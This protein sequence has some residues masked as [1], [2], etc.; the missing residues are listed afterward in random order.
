MSY[1]L[2]DFRDLVRAQLDTDADDLTNPLIDAWVREGWRTCVN[3]NRRWPFYRSTWSVP[4][5]ATVAAYSFASLGSP[6]NQVGELQT[7]LDHEGNPLTWVG[8]EQAQKLLSTS[9]TKPTYWTVEGNSLL[10]F[11]TPGDSFTFT[12]Y[13]YRLPIEWVGVNTGATSDL[14][15][16][17]DDVI[18]NWCIGRAFQRQEDGDLGVMHLD[19]SDFLLRQLQKQYMKYGSSFPLVLNDGVRDSVQPSVVWNV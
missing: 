13:G 12:A 10:L 7:V 16:D 1:T 19:Q 6:T 14:P 17:F 4:V 11:P 8:L 3:R 5:Q 2:Q 18:L 9:S 15:D